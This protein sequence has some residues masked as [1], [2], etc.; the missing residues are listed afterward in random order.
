MHF[1]F[2][3]FRFTINCQRRLDTENGLY[4]YYMYTHVTAEFTTNEGARVRRSERVYF[5]LGI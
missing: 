4:I 1:F 5:I 2:F 3:F